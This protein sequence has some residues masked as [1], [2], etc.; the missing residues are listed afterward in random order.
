MLIWHVSAAHNLNTGAIGR[1]EKVLAALDWGVLRDS[2]G[3]RD[4]QVPSRD[5]HVSS[6]ESYLNK[7][8]R[9]LGQ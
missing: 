3:T 6:R 4:P 8:A 2:Q 7:T 5:P 1:G 9:V